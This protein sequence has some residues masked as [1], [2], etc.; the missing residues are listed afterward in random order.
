MRKLLFFCLLGMAF[1]LLS[2]SN[3][4]SGSTTPDETPN[5]TSFNVPDYEDL[6]PGQAIIHF[7]T[8]FDDIDNGTRT[9]VA[10]FQNER[11]A[12]TF[13]I[14][15]E[16]NAIFQTSLTLLQE[17]YTMVPGERYRIGQE[18]PI[19]L[20]EDGD[21]VGRYIEKYGEARNTEGWT[22]FFTRSGITGEL[23][24]HEVSAE[25]ITG[26]FIF[27]AYKYTDYPFEITHEI[28]VSGS[29]SAACDFDC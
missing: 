13:Y 8:D 7:E 28:K 29:F 1:F 23:V 2:C 5:D 10:T 19:S 18:S 25:Y 17:G 22:Y 21:F 6:G 15:D 11:N 27:T 3:D 9:G 26:S 4:D 14:N 20:P 24:I 12:I 16:K